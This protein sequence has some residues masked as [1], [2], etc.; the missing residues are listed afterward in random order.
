MSAMT[1]YYIAFGPHG[2][3]AL[4]P[5]GE[6]MKIFGYTIIALLVS[7]G[8]FTFTRMMARPPPATM[9]KEYQEMTN[10]YLRVRYPLHT[11]TLSTS[12]SDDIKTKC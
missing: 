7:L 11:L 9:T 3:R 4:P 1:A 8:L 5:P 6:G 10:E 12:F 2:P